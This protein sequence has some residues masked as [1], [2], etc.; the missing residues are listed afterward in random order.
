MFQCV[1]SDAVSWMRSV[2]KQK[3]HKIHLKT[4]VPEALFIKKTDSGTG[5]FL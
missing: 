2:K 3:F 5:V 4:P 1:G